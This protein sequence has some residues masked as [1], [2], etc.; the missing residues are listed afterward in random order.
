MKQLTTDQVQALLTGHTPPCISLYQPTHRSHPDNQQDPIRYR[1]LLSELE[2]SLR[3]KYPTREIRSLMEKFQALAHDD[4]FWNYRTEGLAILSCPDSFQIVELQRPV[5]ELLVVADSFHLKPLLRILQSADRYQILALS[6]QEAKLYEGN[7]DSL[8]IV[9]LTNVPATLQEALGSE[10]TEPHLTV[11]S[12][13]AGASR[14][15]GSGAAPSVHGHGDKKDEVD[16]DR[17]RFFR[18]IDR[19]ILQHHSR[20]SGLPLMLAALPEHHEPFRAL[21]HNPFLMAEGIRKNPGS[22]DLDQ[23]RAEA[24]Q[25]LEPIYLQRLAKLVDDF[26]VARSRQQGAD[27][28]VEV[29]Q[30]AVAGR[31]ATLLIEAERL[32][33]GKI[34]A[35]TGE[36]VANS[37]TGATEEWNPS[38]RHRK[39]G[40]TMPR[41]IFDPEVDDTLDDLA[42]IVLRAKG[43]VIVVPTERM[44][45]S[46]GLAAIYR[47]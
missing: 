28:L 20:P 40:R 18:A 2:N 45:S 1:N 14:A 9:E 44:P 10:L 30:A 27:E 33:P 47:Y 25:V 35:T 39:G 29:A 38:E 43:E 41:D 4:R 21:S 37:L 5:P 13:G 17:D 7:R 12:Y 23:L 42:E 6:R 19:S 26:Q 34:D 22:L 16:G 46:S 15:A 24:W 31:V 11:G 36:V 8:D 3:Q 32:I